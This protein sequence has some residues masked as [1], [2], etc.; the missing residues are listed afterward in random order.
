MGTTKNTNK[1][2]DFIANKYES[3]ELDNNSLVQ[4]IA[5]SFDYLNLMTIADYAKKY[6]LSYNGVKKHRN[7][8]IIG[9]VKF[10]LDN[11]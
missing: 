3:D 4:L 1:L 11:D 10:V 2:I 8:I 7:I 9:G 5:L 6:N